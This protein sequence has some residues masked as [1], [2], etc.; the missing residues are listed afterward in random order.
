MIISQDIG[1]GMIFLLYLVFWFKRMMGELQIRRERLK[2]Y[3]ANLRLIEITINLRRMGF[4][5][6]HS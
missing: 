4:R 2:I 3:R 1:I 6:C 5:R